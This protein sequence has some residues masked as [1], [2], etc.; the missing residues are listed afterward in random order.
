MLRRYLSII[1]AFVMSFS[2]FSYVFS[3]EVSTGDRTVGLESYQSDGSFKNE[4]NVASGVYALN[5]MKSTTI[6][7]KLKLT[8]VVDASATENDLPEQI[9]ITIPNASVPEDTQLETDDLDV[10]GS[11]IAVSP[12]TS[13]VKLSIPIIRD[14]LIT[15]DSV[16]IIIPFTLT[17]LS[18]GSDIVVSLI[19]SSGQVVNY[20][21]GVSLIDVTDIELTLPERL[22]AN[23][24]FMV[25]ELKASSGFK[26]VLPLSLQSVNDER[27][28]TFTVSNPNFYFKNQNGTWTEG[29]GTYTVSNLTAGISSLQQIEVFCFEQP[30]NAFNISVDSVTLSANLPV[31]KDNEITLSSTGTD[32]TLS[33][34]TAGKL[35]MQFT[36]GEQYAGNNSFKF[37]FLNYDSSFYSIDEEHANVKVDTEN[38]I[39]TFEADYTPK[40]EYSGKA[41]NVSVTTSFEDETY[42]LAEHEV[43]LTAVSTGADINDVGVT[44]DL[45]S[46]N[47]IRLSTT[48]YSDEQ[49]DVS[50]TISLDTDK[51]TLST[52][53][54]L[55]KNSGTTYTYNV[56][57]APE[58]NNEKIISYTVDDD[59]NQTPNTI[60]KEITF[61]LPNDDNTSNNT[62]TVS[63]PVAGK[64]PEG[65]IDFGIDSFGTIGSLENG[66]TK[67]T[68]VQITNNSDSTETASV[69]IDVSNAKVSLDS[70]VQSWRKVSDTEYQFTVSIESG[71]TSRVPFAVVV[72]DDCNT[73]SD[74]MPI[75]ITAALT[76]TDNNSANDTKT[77]PIL[78]LA[79]EDI[80]TGVDLKEYFE[81]SFNSTTISRLEPATVSL[82]ATQ[83]KLLPSKL[84]NGVI[85][86]EVIGDVKEQSGTSNYSTTKE[87]VNL[88][89]SSITHSITF[90]PT[91]VGN[92]IVLAHVTCDGVSENGDLTGKYTFTINSDSSAYPEEPITSSDAIKM[93]AELSDIENNKGILTVSVQNTTGYIIRDAYLT[94]DYANILNLKYNG[95]IVRNDMFISNL[96]PETEKVFTFDVE[97]LQSGKTEIAISCKSMDLNTDVFKPAV[98][99]DKY[100]QYTT[101][102]PTDEVFE[103]AGYVFDDSNNNGLMNVNE[104][105]IANATVNLCE[106]VGNILETVRTYSSGYYIFKDVKPGTYVL[107]VDYMGVTHS[108]TITVTDENIVNVNM[109][110]YIN[111]DDENNNNNGNDGDN[112]V[113]IP[114]PTKASVYLLANIVETAQDYCRVEVTVKNKSNVATLVKVSSNIGAQ[115]LRSVSDWN[116]SNGLYYTD[117]F[118]LSGFDSKTL[119]LIVDRNNV[120]S[121]IYFTLDAISDDSFVD[122]SASVIIPAKNYEGNII[123]PNDTDD[124]WDDR[125]DSD[126][127]EDKDKISVDNSI[128]DFAPIISGTSS[129]NN[130]SGANNGVTSTPS[131]NTNGNTNTSNTNNS[132]TSTS[133]NNNQVA[134]NSSTNLPK[135]GESTAVDTIAESIT[136]V[137]AYIIGIISLC[138]AVYRTV[139]LKRYKTERKLN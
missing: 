114:D 126:K 96:P 11:E 60:Y 115:N 33:V 37:E 39:V 97:V 122:N 21:W 86:L 2:C 40:K 71:R 1:L 80:P 45:E 110:L 100:V 83:K 112:D 62:D 18:E 38:R 121:Y 29:E 63:I 17:K 131:T 27:E 25:D 49:K 72:A 66:Q 22:D 133:S 74:V 8:Y 26:Y 35:E 132:N 111:T 53:S 123:P 117:Y 47:T 79:G 42:T 6:T 104:T 137:F 105:G 134:G 56:T 9:D 106:P 51:I 46:N 93:S 4:N 108:E 109:P 59:C 113:I 91:N 32:S 34:G 129:G 77:M 128:A 41:L 52:D 48:N 85:T 78:I 57:L 7:N 119:T 69:K 120:D 94:V 67:E 130:T 107:K 84:Q 101:T 95:N 82:T 70:S 138:F 136:F 118:M 54:T 90:T 23:T 65:N 102:Q 89:I 68:Y 99:C 64:L 19:S 12:T 43:L 139:T 3:A 13:E 88:D 31:T 10:I 81:L 103:V 5:L 50:V 58:G 24:R 36:Y 98:Y 73:T 44:A 76:S 55:I 124:F 28:V 116:G 61:S 15:K 20:N 16:S 14:A 135:T 75:S 127:R 30:T 125:D 87:V 92:Y